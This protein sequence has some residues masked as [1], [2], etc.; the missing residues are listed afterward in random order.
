MAMQEFSDAINM[1]LHS[2]HASWLPAVT[3]GLK[4]MQ[5]ASPAYLDTLLEGQFFPLK[6]R[7]F[8]AF[9]LPIDQ[10][11]YVL[12]GEGPY[13]REESATGVCFMDGAV[14]ELWSAEK[15]GGLSKSVNRATSLRNFIKMLLVAEGLLDVNNTNA[16]AMNAISLRARAQDTDLIQSLPELQ[17][18]LLSHGFLLLNASP[19]FRKEVAPLQD[20]KAWQPFLQVIFSALSAHQ[21]LDAQKPV[22]LLLWGKIAELLKHI[23]AVHDFPAI[24]AEHPYNL[25]FIANKKML[26]FF[27]QFHLLR[28]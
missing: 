5:V 12:I 7:M 25:S 21:K 10:I 15:K 2:V 24:C 3:A 16:E 13:P 26:S 9:E 17:L 20:A 8:A 19:V 18:N 6:G 27:Y 1:A 11:R 23:P 4:A 28:K 14:K 22:T